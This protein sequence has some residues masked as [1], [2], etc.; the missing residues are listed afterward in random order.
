VVPTFRHLYQIQHPMM[1]ARHEGAEVEAQLE[2]EAP[3]EVAVTQQLFPSEEQHPAQHSLESH[4]FAQNTPWPM[5][6]MD[7]TL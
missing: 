5:R 3:Q 1:L 4:L 2:V 7:A 6:A